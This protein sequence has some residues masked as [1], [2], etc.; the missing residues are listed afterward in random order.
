MK[1]E[2]RLSNNRIFICI[3]FIRMYYFK[4]THSR[5]K[6][7]CSVTNSKKVDATDIIRR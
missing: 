7:G 2:M 5:N 3:I 6:K 1:N 4:S